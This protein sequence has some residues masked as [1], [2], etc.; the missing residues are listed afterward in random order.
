LTRIKGV[1]KEQKEQKGVGIRF[2][3]MHLTNARIAEILD[4]EDAAPRH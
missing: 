4:Q 1:L 3:T 2:G